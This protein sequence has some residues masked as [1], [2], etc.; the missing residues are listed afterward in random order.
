MVQISDFSILTE[1][2]PVSRN[3]WPESVPPIPDWDVEMPRV[4]R[5]PPLPP[6]SRPKPSVQK[7]LDA[8]RQAHQNGDAAGFGKAYGALTGEF[9][10]DIQWAIS[11]WEFL[12]TAQ[13]IRFIAR[14]SHEKL[15]SRGDYRVFNQNDFEGLIF[16]SFRECVLNYVQGEG[17][18]GFE[19]FLRKSLWPAV[20]EAYQ[21]L[22][23]PADRNQRKL[24]GYS[25]LRCAPYQF[26]NRYHHERVY[27]IV[28]RLPALLRQAVELY[29]LSFY[30]EEAACAQTGVTPVEFRRRRW[31][32]LRAVASKDLLTFR[33]LR[34]IERY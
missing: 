30:R 25:Y 17:Q 22:E 4:Y 11:C 10:P 6:L 24:T 29:H 19:L 27:K 34:Q 5:K 32:A 16:R 20:S 1:E 15:Y 2:A 13:G 7:L 23:E 31:A 3:R 33:L 21:Q 9:R 12:L 14:N 8:A 18:G 28:R 26:L